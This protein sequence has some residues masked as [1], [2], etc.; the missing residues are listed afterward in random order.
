MIKKTLVHSPFSPAGTVA[1][2]DDMSMDITQ[3]VGRIVPQR[4]QSEEPSS[5]M[6]QDMSMELTMPLGSIQAMASNAPANRRKSLKRR[7]S[8]LDASQ[9]SPAKRPTS[10]RAS[11]RQRRQSEDNAADDATMDLTMAIGGIKSVTTETSF[12]DTTMDFTLA[13]GSIKSGTTT[14]VDMFETDIIDED[15][16]MEFTKIV[17]PGIKRIGGPEATPEKPVLSANPTPSK[18]TTPRKTPTKSPGRRRSSLVVAEAKT[19][20]RDINP[21]YTQ[22]VTCEKP[23]KS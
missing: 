17:G 1:D 5:D 18:T 9:G 16:S 20:I 8:M 11:L 4:Q 15:L 13:V 21:H 14:A 2:D 3:A 6:D 7:V 19:N 10:R 22:E 23:G 12:E